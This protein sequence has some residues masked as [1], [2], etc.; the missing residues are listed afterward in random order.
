MHEVETATQLDRGSK[1]PSFIRPPQTTDQ[2]LT[3]CTGSKKLAAMPHPTRAVYA[4]AA[5]LR[6]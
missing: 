1:Q 6:I 5:F 3:V 4:P 2:T